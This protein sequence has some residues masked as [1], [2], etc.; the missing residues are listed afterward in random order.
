MKKKLAPSLALFLRKRRRKGLQI[1]KTLQAVKR[2][3]SRRHV[4]G[5]GGRRIGRPETEGGEMEMEMEMESKAKQSKA[6]ISAPRQIL[7]PLSP[8]NHGSGL[9]IS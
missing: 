3:F 4:S 2:A 9:F 8:I 7:F 6:R 1:Q 5:G